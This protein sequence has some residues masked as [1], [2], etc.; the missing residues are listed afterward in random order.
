MPSSLADSLQARPAVGG[1]ALGHLEGSP[2]RQEASRR[3]ASEV[4]QMMEAERVVWNRTLQEVQALQARSLEELITAKVDRTLEVIT[5]LSE[6]SEER[7]A[8][9]EDGMEELRR[10]VVRQ[11]EG[12]PLGERALADIQGDAEAMRS[13]LADIQG[14]LSALQPV[15]AAAVAAAGGSSG[16]GGAAEGGQA[17]EQ[18]ALLDL[19]ARAERASLQQQLNEAKADTGA[20]GR[21]LRDARADW[22]AVQQ[23]LMEVKIEWTS[24]QS[25]LVETDTAVASLEQQVRDARAELSSSAAA[26]AATQR[27]SGDS[28]TMLASVEQ[29]QNASKV[30]LVSLKQE[31]AEVKELSSIAAAEQ[32]LQKKLAAAAEQ[33]S[34]E[35]SVEALA[36]LRR[37]LA[38]VS[39]EQEERLG[40]LSVAV[41]EAAEALASESTA[42]LEEVGGVRKRL[43]GDH[44]D[45]RGA[46]EQ[47]AIDVREIEHGLQTRFSSLQEDMAS[48]FKEEMNQ[49]ISQGFHSIASD[50]RQELTRLC[51]DR[52]QQVRGRGDAFSKSIKAL[53]R[54]GG[55]ESGTLLRT[56]AEERAQHNE[57]RAAFGNALAMQQQE[58]RELQQQQRSSSQELVA[59]QSLV[60]TE[61]GAASAEIKRSLQSECTSLREEMAQLCREEA[62][63]VRGSCDALGNTLAE[64]QKGCGEELATLRTLLQQAGQ[65]IS[66]DDLQHEVACILEEELAVLRQSVGRLCDEEVPQL[67][68]S[69]E[70]L[71]MRVEAQRQVSTCEIGDLRGLL[72][73]VA[74]ERNQHN[75]QRTALGKAVTAQQ[76]E[77]R[78]LQA[79]VQAVA[80]ESNQHLEQRSAL[81]RAAAAQQQELR[82]LQAL[83]QQMQQVQQAD[84]SGRTLTLASPSR[85][86]TTTSNTVGE[87]ALT[88]RAFEELQKYTRV[89]I[90][91]VAAALD[92]ETRR[93][94]RDESTLRAELGNAI[95]QE[96]MDRSVS[97][98]K[99]REER[100]RE[101]SEFRQEVGVAIRS[102]HEQSKSEK[103]SGFDGCWRTRAAGTG[104]EI[105]GDVLRWPSGVQVRMS[106]YDAD[107]FSI[108]LQGTT[109][110]AQLVSGGVEVVWDDGDVWTLEADAA[111]NS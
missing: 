40:R 28:R 75:E 60:H 89:E 99:E 83:M 109:H 98:A 8:G 1:E 29:Q 76:Q 11:D 17:N 10:A 77:L 107:G 9:V 100:I 31:L 78:E 57:Q 56:V 95:A 61:R 96:R 20:L 51:E 21:Q 84:G 45:L 22:D 52:M 46:L 93:R 26:A 69:F 38:E 12:P 90:D 18:A 5:M 58:V 81:G 64:L 47:V 101:S 85:K 102:W 14:L 63:Q 43:Q 33:H 94:L 82:E 4:Q 103:S 30:E 59:L 16:G 41:A 71:S 62:Q 92:A 24:A 86:G 88:G 73:A 65:G 2:S 25:R 15:A 67:R 105:S 110:R 34:R 72:Q 6:A 13:Q 36:S 39:G 32:Q 3:A 19:E 80:A 54:T 70:A 44:E 23:Q 37:E 48:L 97:L 42:R 104:V 68:H 106:D 7:F 55:E 79:S 87:I 66:G 35:A 108:Q 27:H 91:K 50:L 111:S 74:E 49:V 53:P